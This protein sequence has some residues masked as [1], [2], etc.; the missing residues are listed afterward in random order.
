MNSNKIKI[1]VTCLPG[2][3]D[4]LFEE[5][6]SLGGRQVE[7]HRR[8]VLCQGDL[9]LIYTLNIY[10][11]FALR[12]LLH[13]EHCSIR[14][15][16]DMYRRVYDIDWPKYF[17]VNNTIAVRA[18]FG[19]H[20]FKNTHYFSL[21]AKDAIVDRFR[22]VDGERPSIDT[23]SPDVGIHLYYDSGDLDIYLDSSGYS[24][25]KRGYKQ[26]LGRAS[27]SETLAAAIF[28]WADCKEGQVIIN[29]MCGVGTLAIEAGLALSKQSPQK[30]RSTFGFRNWLNYD[31]DIYEEVREIEKT[32]LTFD[33][34]CSD[35]DDRSVREC[36]ENVEEADLSE[37][38]SFSTE[39]FFEMTPIDNALILLNPPYDIRLKEN[40]VIEFYKKI[41]DTL[42]FKWKNCRCVIISANLD[43]F[44]FVGLRPNKK[45]KVFNGPLPAEVR[46]FDIY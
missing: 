31:H 23:K 30:N 38:F 44:K 4:I 6:Q 34:R 33:I 22:K 10:C 13:L 41:G 17:E 32:E 42:K 11:R 35:I 25:H 27:I 5:I 16:E 29:P 3:E 39:D 2:L 20:D 12:V 19:R 1:T 45:H 21:K 43:A 9:R 14:D 40:D 7:K 24:L 26:Y 15:E 28:R 8:A 18:A 37:H 46:I 36:R